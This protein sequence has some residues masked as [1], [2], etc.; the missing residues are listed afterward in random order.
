MPVFN[1][2]ESHAPYKFQFTN[3]DIPSGNTIVSALISNPETLFSSSTEI[4]SAVFSPGTIVKIR[5]AGTY[6]TGVTAL[7]LTVRIKSGAVNLGVVTLTP[8]L[9][10]S[11]KGWSAEVECNVFDLQTV[12]IQGQAIFG[13][14]PDPYAIG[15]SS[16]FL[17]NMNNNVP[18]SASATWGALALGGSIQMRQFIVQV[19]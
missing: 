2:S 17:V 1:P 3:P 18:I 10:L 7:P 9:N 15:N 4:P 5:I 12:D 14:M 19:S 11:N 8:L 13:G 6:T 16:N